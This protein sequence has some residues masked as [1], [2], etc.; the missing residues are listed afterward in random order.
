MGRSKAEPSFLM[1]AGA[2]LTT[3]CFRGKSKPVF[4]SA[5]RTRLFALFHGRIGKAHGGKKGQ[6][7]ARDIDLNFYRI[8]IDAEHCGADDL[9]EHRA[10]LVTLRNADLGIWNELRKRIAEKRKVCQLKLQNDP[11]LH[12]QRKGYCSNRVT[13]A[14]MN[15]M[16]RTYSAKGTSLTT[17]LPV[18]PSRSLS[19]AAWIR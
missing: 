8:G 4:L 1:S 13:K 16:W 5:A 9:R 3:T 18:R 15:F 11:Y 2:R 6:S 17:P 10:P 7:P 19:P 12:A 14:P